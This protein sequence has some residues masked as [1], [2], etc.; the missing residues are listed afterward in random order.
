MYKRQ[1][2]AIR[3]ETA[4]NEASEE[5]RVLYVAM[6]R[7]KEKL[8][9][10]GSGSGLQRALPKLAAQVTEQGISPYAVRSVRNAGHWLCLLYT[11]RCV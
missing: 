8:I 7:A 2:E 10:V 5:L 3:L 4:R 6:T 9:L 11:S 1:R